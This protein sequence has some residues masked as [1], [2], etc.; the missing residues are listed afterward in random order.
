MS[1]LFYIDERNNH[2]LRP[3]CVKLCPDLSVLKDK[4]AYFIILAYDNHSPFRQFPEH[5]RVR[6]A[7]FQ[8]FGED[9]SEIMEKQ[10]IKNAIHAYRSL[11]YDPKIELGKRYQNKIDKMLDLLDADDSPSSIEKTTKAIDSLRKN[12]QALE[13]E[14]A[15]SVL[16]KGVIKGDMELSFLEDMMQN[17]KYYES[18]IAK[19]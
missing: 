10:S 16:D 4:E 9:M 17:K 7:M 3:D 8:A 18:V 12:I 11:Q 2:V 14:V 13:H 19:K 5:D 1:L 6:K 15:Q